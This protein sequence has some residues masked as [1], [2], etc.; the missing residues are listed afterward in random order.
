LRWTIK[1]TLTLTLSLGKG[2]GESI[3]VSFPLRGERIK[4]RGSHQMNRVVALIAVFITA[5]KT[6]PN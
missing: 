6:L 5:E 1:K 3:P 2:E 4:V